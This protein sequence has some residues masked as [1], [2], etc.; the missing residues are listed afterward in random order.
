VIP[1]ARRELGAL[2]V[3]LLVALGFALGCLIVAVAR[4]L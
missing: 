3:L 1:R 2:L 4:V